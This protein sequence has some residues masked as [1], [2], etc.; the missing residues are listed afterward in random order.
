MI[1]LN[2]RLWSVVELVR[3]I[4]K[5]IILGSCGSFIHGQLLVL[6]LLLNDLLF[7]ECAHTIYLMVT[8]GGCGV[9]R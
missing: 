2:I 6:G 4:P 5:S 1:I 8:R 7:N 9:I 3:V